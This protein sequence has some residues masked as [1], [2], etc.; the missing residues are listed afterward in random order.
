MIVPQEKID[1]AK[2]IYNVIVGEVKIKWEEH[3]K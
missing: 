2:R 3:M 1:E